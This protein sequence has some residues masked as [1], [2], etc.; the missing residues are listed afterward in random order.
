MAER[1]NVRQGRQEREFSELLP[2]QVAT[3]I[4]PVSLAG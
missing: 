2:A 1:I 4:I 3:N